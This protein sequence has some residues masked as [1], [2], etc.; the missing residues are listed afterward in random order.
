[1]SLTTDIIGHN[2]K[3]IANDA[4]YIEGECMRIIH[5]LILKA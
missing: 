2:L 5:L 4:R 1:M 3:V